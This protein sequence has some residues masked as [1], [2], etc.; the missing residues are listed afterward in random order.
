MT[1]GVKCEGPAVAVLP[2]VGAGID[3]R[4]APAPDF[5]SAVAQLW[6]TRFL[7]TMGIAGLMGVRE[8][9]VWKARC[10]LDRRKGGMR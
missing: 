4:K 7:S 9:D 3:W 2:L 1:V 6:S 10:R 5:D 8:A